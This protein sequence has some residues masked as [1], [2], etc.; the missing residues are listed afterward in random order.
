MTI[1]SRSAIQSEIFSLLPDNNDK[2]IT[3]QDVRTVVTDLNDSYVS[4]LGDSQ[5]QGTIQ[6][7]SS[8]VISDDQDLI[9]KKY[10]EDN[11]TS[12]ITVSN[13]LT[14]TGDNITWE[15][16]LTKNT[17]IDLATFDLKFTSG[18]FDKFTFD[19][20]DG[21]FDAV[22]GF[23]SNGFSLLRYNDTLG[24]LQLGPSPWDVDTDGV[25]NFSIG[26][27]NFTNIG[28][29]SLHNTVL[30]QSCGQ[31]IVAGAYN[32]ILGFNSGNNEDMLGCL[33]IGEMS[34]SLSGADTFYSMAFGPLSAVRGSNEL[35]F[36]A[37][38]RPIQ[39]VFFGEGQGSSNSGDR[40]SIFLPVSIHSQGDASG[41][42]TNASAARLNLRASRGT[43]NTA[44]A[45]V[46]LQYAP[47]GS[48]GSSVN[49]WAD[50]LTL[51]GEGNVEINNA[52]ASF[53]IGDGGTDGSWRIR[54]VGTDLVFDRRESGSWI[55]KGDF[56]A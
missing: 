21:V 31:S 36:G 29:S 44:S 46:V 25:G 3:A 24:N 53:I 5:V 40:P 49:A 16:E 45:P 39:N 18:A 19:S 12:P 26:R 32:T 9:T 17:E 8:V 22:G 33:F 1:K 50:G 48:S 13:G 10:F 47:A 52:S 41:T 4:K 14:R 54:I 23:N 35:V 38:S 30:G 7:L 2:E 15:G 56:T 34:D 43:G 55:P 51:D 42:N 37:S 11:A 27:N 20:S 6:Y 28:A